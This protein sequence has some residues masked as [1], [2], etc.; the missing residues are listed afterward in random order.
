MTWANK[1]G[2]KWCGG[3]G[4]LSQSIGRFMVIVRCSRFFVVPHCGAAK[5]GPLFPRSS[6]ISS[7][8]RRLR[9]SRKYNQTAWAMISGGKRAPGRER[10]APMGVAPAGPQAQRVRFTPW[11][12]PLR[13][14]TMRRHCLDR[15]D[16]PSPGK[17][18]P[19]HQNGLAFQHAIR[20]Q[21]RSSFHISGAQR[22][23]TLKR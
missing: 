7:T 20:R 8:C 4:S 2:N 18:Q 22:T 3:G 9:G 16:V 1:L 6:S 11:K 10:P 12:V 13:S 21:P 5:P 14:A 17:R 15:E 23:S 19:R